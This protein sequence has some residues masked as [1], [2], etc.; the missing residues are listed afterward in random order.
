MPT[1]S[2]VQTHLSEKLAILVAELKTIAVHNEHTDDWV[3][4]PDTSDQSLADANSEAD[5]TE[6][7]NERRATL[8]SLETEYRDVTRA[9][10]KISTHTYGICE[11]CGEE[12]EPDRLAA[13]LTAR[14]CIA[15]KDEESQ[16]PL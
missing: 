1:L 7:W 12:V 3:A 16:L 10:S 5:T 2:E 4:V 8:A 14:T 9:I 13:K 6:E 15:H 11:L